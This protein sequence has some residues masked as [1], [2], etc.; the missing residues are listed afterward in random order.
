MSLLIPKEFKAQINEYSGYLDTDS[1]QGEREIKGLFLSPENTAYLRT[2]IVTLLSRPQ[3]IADNSGHFTG[4][5]RDGPPMYN[6][7]IEPKHVQLSKLFSEHSGELKFVLPNLMA[8]NQLPK[9]EDL[10]NA[11]PIQQLHYINRDFLLQTARTIVL[12]PDILVGNYNYVNHDTG[13]E[14]FVEYDYS[15]AS[16]AD[17]VWRPEHLFTESTRNRQNPYWTLSRVEF[18]DTPEATGPGNK[19]KQFG[20]TPDRRNLYDEIDYED[21]NV[22]DILR[23][24]YIAEHG[25]HKDLR[26]TMEGDLHTPISASQ[27]RIRGVRKGQFSKGA[28]VPFWQATVQNRPYD[29]SDEGLRAAGSNDRRRQRPH[30]YNMSTLANRSSAEDRTVPLKR[31]F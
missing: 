27:P 19:W 13:K 4:G 20:E 31:T 14:E 2:A 30:G 23:M 6:N 24:D 25:I 8:Q 22:D 17:G 21:L 15:A 7:K 10:V 29:R 5:E 12:S 16:Y 26:E 18:S 11:N 9:D 3:F 28:Q 1:V